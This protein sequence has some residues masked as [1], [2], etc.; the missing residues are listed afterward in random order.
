MAKPGRDK[1]PKC[2]KPHLSNGEAFRHKDKWGFPEW[3]KRLQVEI[4]VAVAV[5]ME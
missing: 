4:G 1:F 3:G 2:R 5:A